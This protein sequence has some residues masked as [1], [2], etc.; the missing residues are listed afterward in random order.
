[1]IVEFCQDVEKTYQG[2]G[3][4]ESS[5]GHPWGA[6][7][8]ACCYWEIGFRTCRMRSLLLVF[9]IKKVQS[10]MIGTCCV[11]YEKERGT[12]K[13]RETPYIL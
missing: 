13:T 6:W 12:V 8:Q 10:L 7:G 1:M 9:R 11:V 5:E 2:V 3:L 4:P